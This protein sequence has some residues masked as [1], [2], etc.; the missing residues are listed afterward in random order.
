VGY[1]RIRDVQRSQPAGEPPEQWPYEGIKLGGVPSYLGWGGEDLDFQPTCK[2]CNASMR[3][4]GQ[5]K[6]DRSLE[7][8]YSGGDFTIFVFACPTHDEPKLE[9][10]VG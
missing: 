2:E 9:A 7:Y 6:S 1:A 4:L 3:F 5:L 8:E 10:F